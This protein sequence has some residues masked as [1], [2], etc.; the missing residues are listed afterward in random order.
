MKCKYHS[1]VCD[2]VTD[3]CYSTTLKSDE[4]ICP[5]ELELFLR[6]YFKNLFVKGDIYCGNDYYEFSD[7]IFTNIRN[8]VKYDK[9]E[10]KLKTE[11]KVLTTLK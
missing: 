3:E 2:Q 9:W 11:C 6:F 7:V 4:S 8:S 1:N 10:S 5:H